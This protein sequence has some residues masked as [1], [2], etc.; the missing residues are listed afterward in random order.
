M[1]NQTA[2]LKPNII[3]LILFIEGLISVSFQVIFIRQ[4]TPFVGND[5]TVIGLVIGIYLTALSLGYF[6]GGK[7][8]GDLEKLSDNMLFSAIWSGIFISTWV[9]SLWFVG[10]AGFLDVNYFLLSVYLLV[11][12][13]PIVYLLGH[14]IPIIVD[15][16]KKDKASNVAGDSLGINTIGSVLGAVLTPILLFDIFGVALTIFI[17]VCSLIFLYLL[18]QYSTKG[19]QFKKVFFV[20]PFIALAYWLNVAKSNDIFVKTTAYANYAVSSYGDEYGNHSSIMS[21]NSSA[22]SV[23]EN[24]HHTGYVRYLYN[25]MVDQLGFVENDVLILGSGGFTFSMNDETDNRYT[26]V[27][28][29]PRIKDIAEKFFLQNKIRGQFVAEDARQFVGNNP[30]SYDAI[31]VDLFSHNVSMPWHVTTQEFVKKVSN[32]LRPEGYAMFNIIHEMGFNHPDNKRLHNTIE[33]VFNYCF[34]VPLYNGKDIYANVVYI[35]K[36]PD[37]ELP[38]INIDNRQK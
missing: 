14:T 30:E 17:C 5:T 11:G 37:G 20:L 7:N 18:L 2:T 16:I 28:I 35:C 6:K 21:L 15:L 27:D 19:L 12:L 3:A 9:M 8:G 26:Y 10:G 32:G 4:L 22:A 33:S 29:D 23:I 38:E 34:I 36:K 25:F 1:S 13:F 31:F 24:G